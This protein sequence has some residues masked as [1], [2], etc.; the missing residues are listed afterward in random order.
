VTREE[1][2]GGCA[3]ARAAGRARAGDARRTDRAAALERALSAS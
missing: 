1:I 3:A 2:A